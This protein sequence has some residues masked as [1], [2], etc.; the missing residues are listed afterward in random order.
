MKRTFET[1]AFIDQNII[2]FRGKIKIANAKQKNGKA[3]QIQT[4]LAGGQC[5]SAWSACGCSKSRGG[6]VGRGR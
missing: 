5:E 1:S 6:C 4:N 3:K 2:R